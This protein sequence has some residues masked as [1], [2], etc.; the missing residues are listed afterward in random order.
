MPAAI[1]ARAA[2][3]LLAILLT[4]ASAQTS[5]VAVQAD[6]TCAVT[7]P[8]CIL[9]V[10][11]GSGMAFSEARDLAGNVVDATIGVQLIGCDEYDCYGPVYAYPAEDIWL[12]P[13]DPHTSGCAQPHVAIPDHATDVAGWTEFAA[14]PRAGGWAEG[15]VQVYVAGAPGGAG[16]LFDIPSLPIAFNSPDLDGDLRVDITDVALFAHDLGA[17]Y[18]F[19]SD[20]SWDGQLDLSDIAVFVAHLGAGCE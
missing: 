9:V 13:A 5:L 10:P 1:L 20:L 8:V 15:P 17:G 7:G 19:R 12:Q 18:A 6:Q 4:T 14:A 3:P 11:D 16:G 2:V